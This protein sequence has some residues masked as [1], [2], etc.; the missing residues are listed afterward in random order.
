MKLLKDYGAFWMD[1]R[2]WEKW[3]QLKQLAAIKFVSSLR[4]V[5]NNVVS[6]YVYNKCIHIHLFYLYIKLFYENVQLFNECYDE[7]I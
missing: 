1:L 7:I 5:I 2:K 4:T 6:F 3:I